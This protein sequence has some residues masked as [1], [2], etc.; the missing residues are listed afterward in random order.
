VRLISVSSNG[1][2]PQRESRNDAGQ[3]L[4]VEGDETNEDDQDLPIPMNNSTGKK[5]PMRIMAMN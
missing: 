3:I 4:I 1:C 5:Q 2:V